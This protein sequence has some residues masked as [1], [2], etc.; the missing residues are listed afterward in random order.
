MTQLQRATF[1]TLLVLTEASSE[2]I[3]KLRGVL[4]EPH[5]DG[6]IST[7]MWGLFREVTNTAEG[8]LEAIRRLGA[9]IIP[10]E[11]AV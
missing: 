3:Q 1:A 11:G 7:E 10:D 2:N 6:T 4:A 5:D 8:F 9:H